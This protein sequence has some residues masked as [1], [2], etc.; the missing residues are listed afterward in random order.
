MDCNKVRE[1]VPLYALGALEPAELI[2][3]EEH[4]DRCPDCAELARADLTTTMALA[5]LAP[6]AEPPASLRYRVMAAA[7]APMPD[8]TTPPQPA[9]MPAPA[10]TGWHRWSGWGLGVTGAVASVSL[11]LAGMVLALLLDVRSDVGELQASLQASNDEL[12]ELMVNQQDSGLATAMP[13]GIPMTLQSTEEAPRARG[14]LITSQDRTW[15]VL[16]SLGL[17]PQQDEMAYQVW[18]ITDGLR[19]SG[20]VFSVDD[21]GYGEIYL[22]FPA[23]LDEIT[24]IGVTEE[25]MEGSLSP[26]SAPILTAQLP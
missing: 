13:W 26:S 11:V 25:P 19:L 5:S 20:G 4:L 1:L 23:E 3:V 9:P 7:G 24:G 18:F 15:G 10:A 8:Q 12:V 21:T 6:P 22:R 16:Y 2:A 14:M 17:E